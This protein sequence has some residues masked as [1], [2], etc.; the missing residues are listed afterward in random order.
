VT[1][2]AEYF[3]LGHLARFVEPGAVRIESTSWGTTGWNGEIMDAAFRNPDG[4]IALV[5]HN[6]NDAPRSFAVAQGGFSLEYTL[7][8]GSLATFT[9]P[10]IRGRNQH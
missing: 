5:V 1:R 4:S 9:W 10:A 7:P 3:T 2:N 8:G 6:E